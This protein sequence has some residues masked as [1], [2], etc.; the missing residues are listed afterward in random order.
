MPIKSSQK[1][2][3]IGNIALIGN[4]ILTSLY[5][6]SLAIIQLQKAIRKK[7]GSPLNKHLS[8]ANY[9]HDC[10]VI[11]TDSPAWAARLR[12]QSADILTFARTWPDL[13]NLQTVRIKVTPLNEHQTKQSD[14]ISISSSTADLLRT[15]AENINDAELRVS[16]LRLSEHR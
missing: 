8:V 11:I 15:V 4:N 3:P 1:Y 10:L 5:N 7:L 9:N 2:E 12:F 14:N 16:L 6:H 13:K